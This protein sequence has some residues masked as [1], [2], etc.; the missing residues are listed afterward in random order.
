MTPD[1]KNP[2]GWKWRRSA[3]FGTLVFCAGLIAYVVIDKHDTE[4]GRLTV[5]TLGG[6]LASTVGSYV[7]GAAWERT[8]GLS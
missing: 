6:I 2:T 5:M 3:V 8:K 1:P 7:F 4:L